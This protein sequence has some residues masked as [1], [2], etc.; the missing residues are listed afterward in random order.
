MAFIPLDPFNPVPQPPNSNFITNRVD[1]RN[2][3]PQNAALTRIIDQPST[4]AFS[5]ESMTWRT[6]HLGY[7]KMYLNPNEYKISDKKDITAKR[8][9]GGFTLQ[10]AGEQLTKI[11]ISGTTGSSGIEGINILHSVYRSEQQAFE[12]ISV[13][14]EERL[15]ATQADTLLNSVSPFDKLNL[16]QFA[17]DTLRNIGRPQPTLA[18]LA[19]QIE[20]Y[21]QGTLFRGWFESFSVTESASK[22]GLFDYSIE[23]TAYARQGV[24]RNFM[25]WHRQPYQPA[26]S[27]VNPLSFTYSNNPIPEAVPPEGTIVDEPLTNSS[28]VPDKNSLRYTN[29]GTDSTGTNQ[30]NSAL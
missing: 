26:D 8:T 27:N 29:T 28:Q 15:A 16:F 20:L 30:G 13:A 21:F 14:L 4:G 10:Y 22:P 23:F 9:K 5:R 12:G 18:S 19:T 17:N 25:P 11:N 3:Y 24:R 2:A 7:V 1:T 6:P